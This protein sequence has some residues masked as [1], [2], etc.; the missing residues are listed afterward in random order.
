MNRYSELAI[1]YGFNKREWRD[2]KNK[3]EANNMTSQQVKEEFGLEGK[4]LW[5]LYDVLLQGKLNHLYTR[6]KLTKVSVGDYVYVDDFDYGRGEVIKI[7]KDKELMLVKFDAR[8][9]PTMCSAKTFTTVHDDKKRQL[10][11]L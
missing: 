8:T 9:L 11:K 1:T 7:F 10:T 2:I 3:V 6:E 4:Q 5:F